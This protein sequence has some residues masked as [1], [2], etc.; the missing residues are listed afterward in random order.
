MHKYKLIKEYPN[1]EIGDIAV[2]LPEEN[3]CNFL[4]EKDKGIISQDFQPDVT[5]K[6]FKPVFEV[7][8]YVFNYETRI[9]PFVIKI[10]NI[11]KN[12]VVDNSSTYH[13]FNHFRFA[14]NEEIIKYN[15]EIIK[16]YEQKGW[17][18]GAKFKFENKI[19]TLYKIVKDHE[20]PMCGG[21]IKGICCLLEDY[22]DNFQVM[23][24]EDCELVKEPQYPKS[25][26]D[27]EGIFGCYISIDSEIC[28]NTHKYSSS[29]GNINLFSNKKQA[30]SALAFAQLSQLHKAMID[31][32]N[33]VNNCDWKPNW[34]NHFGEN[35]AVCRFFNKICFFA[36]DDGFFQPLSF[37]TKEMAQ[38]S[39]ENHRELWK[40]YYQL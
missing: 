20:Y 8:D 38:F 6:W 28:E 7:G 34:N 10:E 40:Q 35:W 18:E 32:Y 16:Y 37:P 2:Y 31:E 33:K 11:E 22:L 24:M 13:S 3:D 23:L 17:V 15:D 12:Y 39:L 14:T 19:Y 36:K 1:R 9:P 26:H 25:S 30:E 21:I 5:P 4:W 27:L 29:L